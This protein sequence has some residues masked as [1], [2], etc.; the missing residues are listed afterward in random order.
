MQQKTQQKT[1]QKIIDLINDAE[2]VIENVV[3]PLPIS[4]YAERKGKPIKIIRI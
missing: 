3:V 2:D 1:Q 4:D